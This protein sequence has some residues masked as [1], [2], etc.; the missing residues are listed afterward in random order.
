M[1]RSA[2]L[3]ALLLALGTAGCSGQDD[4]K[5]A[6]AGAPTSSAAATDGEGSQLKFSQCMR[7]Q[8]L[9]WFPD[10]GADGGLKVSNPPGTDESKVKKAEQACRPYAPGA[11][12]NGPPLSEADLDK[13][14]QVSQCIRDHGFSKYPDPDANGGISINQQL[15]GVEPDDPAFQKALRECQKYL[16][17]RKGQGNG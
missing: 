14:R 9:S 1:R 12:R 4:P 11:N 17:P 16:P 7:A 2:I 8:G 3:L 15:I 13:V 5:V 6:T 10:P